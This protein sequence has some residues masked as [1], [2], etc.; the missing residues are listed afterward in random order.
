MHSYDGSGVHSFKS[1]G[2]QKDIKVLKLTTHCTRN[3]V[4]WKGDWS[5]TRGWIEKRKAQYLPKGPGGSCRQ[6]VTE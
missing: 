2:H 6:N 3:V 4:Q 1:R 5:T